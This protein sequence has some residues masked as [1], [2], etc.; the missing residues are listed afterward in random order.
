MEKTNNNFKAS[1]IGSILLALL[2]ILVSFSAINVNTTSVTNNNAPQA[3]KKQSDTNVLVMN[4]SVSS[5]SDVFLN[6]SLP[7][8]GET[9]AD[10][11]EI[12]DWNELSFIDGSNTDGDWNSSADSIW[13]DDSNA[14]GKFDLGFE[15]VLAGITPDDQAEENG[16]GARDVQ[17][18]RI[19]TID[20]ADGDSWNGSVDAIV[21]DIDD[22][23][24]YMDKLTAITFKLNNSGNSTNTDISELLFWN[25]TSGGGFSS[26]QDTLIASASYSA[27]S[28]SWNI[29]GLS[30]PINTS[31]TFYVTVNISGSAVHYKNIVMEIPTLNDQNLDGTW[32][33]DDQGLYLAGS[34]DTGGIVNANGILIDTFAPETEV[35]SFSFYWNNTGTVEINTTSLDNLSGIASVS[36]YYYNSTDN[37]TWNGPVTVGSDSVYPYNWTFDFSSYNGSGWY[38]FYTIGTDTVGNVETAPVSNDTECGFDETGPTVTITLPADGSYNSTILPVNWINGTCTDKE[39]G[40]NRSGVSSVNITIY[41][42]TS[43]Y[44]WNGSG[45]NSAKTWLSSTPA[46]APYDSW[47]Y[48]SSAVTFANATSYKI[49]A[50]GTDNAGNVGT[51]V[52][53]TI[54]YDLY[55]PVVTITIPTNNGNYN[56]GNLTQLSGTS[57]DAYS[58]I[59]TVNITIYNAT[60]GTY[61]NFSGTPGWDTGINWTSVSLYAGYASWYYDS[62]SITWANNS[63]YYI[64]CT[65]TDNASNVGTQVSSTFY[66]DTHAVPTNLSQAQPYWYTTSGTPKTLTYT[67]YESATDSGIKN[68]TLYYR[69]CTDN[70]TWGDWVIWS[71]SSN[72]DTDPWLTSTFD[73]NFPNLSGY[74]EFYTRSYDNASNQE[75]EPANNDTIIGYDIVDPNATIALPTDGGFYKSSSAIDTN[76]TGTASDPQSINM[77][78]ITI[79]N[80]TDGRYFNGSD[81]NS[82][83]A[84]NLTAN[85]TGSGSTIDW[86]YGN[87]T[88]YPSWSTNKSITINVSAKDTAGNWNTSAATASFTYDTTNPNA[89]TITSPTDETWYNSLTNITGSA[90][91]DGGSKVQTVNITIYNASGGRYWNGNCWT[92]TSTNLAANITGTGW[93]KNWYYSNTG[94]FPSSFTNGSTYIVNATST[95]YADNTGSA[96]SNTF[97]YDNN[98]LTSYVNPIAT[99]WQTSESISINATAADSGSGIA[100]VALYYHHSTDNQTFNSSILVATNSTPWLDPSAVGFTF[101]FTNQNGSGYYRFYTVAT[102]NA[103]NTETPSP[104]VT[105]DTKCGYDPT[106]PQVG[107]TIPVDGNYY[108][109]MNWINGTCSDSGYSG[110]NR[111][112]ITIYNATGGTYWNGSTW[113]SGVNWTLT[114]EAGSP[115]TTWSCD[116]SVLTWEDNATYIINATSVDNATRS[117]TAD[118]NSFTLDTT[119]PTVTVEMNRST[120]IK[121]NQVVRIFANFTEATSGMNESDVNFT[122]KNATGTLLEYGALTRDT[123]LKWYYDWTVPAGN[124][125]NVNVSIIATDNVSYSISGVYYNISKYIDNTAPTIT[126]AIEFNSSEIYFNDSDYVKIYANF[127][128]AMSGIDESSVTITITNV[129]SGS[130][131][132]DHTGMTRTTNTEWYY[133]WDIPADENCQVNISIQATDNVSLSLSGTNYTTAKYIDNINPEVII[134][135]PTNAAYKDENFVNITGTATDDT[136]GVASVT[137]TI[138]NTTGGTYYDGTSAWGATVANISCNISGSGTSITWYYSDT[139]SFP[140]WTDGSNYTINATVTDNA[141]N[142]NSNNDSNLFYFDSSGPTISNVIIT[143]VNTTSTSFISDGVTINVTANVSDANLGSGD[144]T[145]IKANLTM[146]GGNAATNASGYDGTVAYWNISGI[147]CTPDDGTII[148]TINASDKSGNYATEVND[149]ITAD[150]TAPTLKYA[151]LD[152]DNDGTDY[153]YVDLY[154]VEDNLDTSTIDTSDFNISIS[155][156]SVSSIQSSAGNRTTIKFDTT[157]QT[158]DSPTIGIAGSIADL[159]GNTITSGTITILTFNISLISGLN[160]VSFPCDVSTDLL[161]TVLSDLSGTWTIYRYN[162]SINDWQYYNP[163]TGY[164]PADVVWNLS[165]GEGYWI[166]AGTAQNLIGS[167][168]L[169]PDPGYTMPSYTLKGQSWNLIG[170]W[171]AYNQTAS[172]GAGGALVSLEDTDIGSVWRYNSGG[173]Y[174]NIFTNN[175]NMVA[176]NGY[177]LW[178]ESTGDKVYTP[179]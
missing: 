2:L 53:S 78:N 24:V 102:D 91:D 43:G 140:T 29:T 6:G 25:E 57:I 144:T 50:T 176:G 167:Y 133:E 48:D 121:E 136:A 20:S 49:N 62:S 16:T 79:Y 160:L 26:S 169:W 108:T 8:I 110:I 40:D 96:D 31:Q 72:P 66:Y 81:W 73:F 148:I 174:T 89:P 104:P 98:G 146:V 76:I 17:W 178:K 112:N 152:S 9:L 60:G 175:Q 120:Y 116:T 128:E 65:G 170:Q 12:S 47:S 14:N 119:A 13:I 134:T 86:Y 46:G 19:K 115:Y 107:I 131:I 117:S 139:A 147:D 145:Y 68:V 36:L 143:N 44:Y 99:Y 142:V 67:Y 22:N 158:G 126:T 80:S 23:G 18:T 114:S 122:I 64:N 168:D 156:V 149:T 118:S 87:L 39:S 45:W 88:A 111:V 63:N 75:A 109:S 95:D 55:A 77:V 150:N 138:Y 151:V 177:W 97:Y 10:S 123:N 130:L 28:S 154:F 4:F 15:T 71:N 166:S 33:A 21:F 41:N 100:S 69:F 155:G 132:V 129:S 52:S 34:N 105:N 7:S 61:W 35:N 1:K 51:K 163:T 106:N 93:L 94:T 74:Y 84:R 113:M 153:T 124:D 59:S 30:I 83:T 137:I 127:T 38:R 125:G 171:Q 179:S 92:T 32:N 85:L 173:G 5:G 135:D 101:N 37:S 70:S 161:T 82:Q 90:Q 56:A 58:G 157:F 165:G 172:T 141:D 42:V 103:T 159:A 54:Y 11:G 162:A 164:I 27:G 3:F